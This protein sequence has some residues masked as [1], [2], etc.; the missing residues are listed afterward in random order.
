MNTSKIT[1]KELIT[2]SVANLPTRPNAPHAFGGTGLTAT[3]LN[4][5]FDA[6]PKLI[7]ERFN[8]LLEDISAE[9]EGGIT[10]SVKTGLGTDHTLYNMLEDI[11]SGA[12]ISYLS[13]PSGTVAEY[14]LSLREDVDRIK[15][16][17]GITETGD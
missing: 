16:A 14:L 9:G 7:A 5:A 11:K 10:G 13:A 17:L 12:F 15:A 1:T 2:K 6:L 3:E 8:L 4:D